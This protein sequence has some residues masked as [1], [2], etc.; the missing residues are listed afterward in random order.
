M[1][2]LSEK[3][4][5][6]STEKDEAI[7]DLQL[8]LKV[9]KH[10][11][12]TE[13]EKLNKII[14]KQDRALEKEILKGDELKRKYLEQIKCLEE[15]RKQHIVEIT[16]CRNVIEKKENEVQDLRKKVEEQDEKVKRAELEKKIL[17]LEKNNKVLEMQKKYD[18]E[19]AQLKASLEK[20][21]SDMKLQTKQSKLEKSMA[22]N[23]HL[24]E[25]NR[26]EKEKYELEKEKNQLE[27]EK[28][29]EENKHLQLK[30]KILE[31]NVQDRHAVS[32][33][34][35][36]NPKTNL[37]SRRNQTEMETLGKRTSKLDISNQDTRVTQPTH[38][39]L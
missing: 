26:L 4:R 28:N 17:H 21:E 33:C 7:A 18:G 1:Q 14:D 29:E 2:Y 9:K 32:T 3:E 8:K 39:E 23:E 15:E 25:K 30:I 31:E 10:E 24:K 16:D 5:R 36:V 37:E 11:L 35:Q 12:K 38:S 19:I 27:K 20:A 6:D 13:K 22:E 34:S